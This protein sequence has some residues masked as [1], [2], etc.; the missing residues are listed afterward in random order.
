MDPASYNTASGFAGTAS[1]QAV[2]NAV[3]SA[4][5]GRPAEEFPS[6][7]TLIYGPVLRGTEVTS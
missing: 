3:L 1:E 6:I 4:R 5:T 2:V 7:A